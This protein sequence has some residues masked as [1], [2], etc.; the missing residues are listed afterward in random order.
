[1]KKD[2]AILCV[3]D[4]PIILESLKAELNQTFGKEF[5]IEVA[6]SG[7]EALEVLDFLAERKISTLVIISD[8][9]MPEMKG[10]ELLATVHK[11]FPKMIKIMLSGQADPQAVSRAETD[12]NSTFVAKPWNKQALIDLIQKNMSGL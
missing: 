2:K 7:A 10:D 8:W 6:E 12:A 4:E 11:K 3:D 9:L 1:M 5:M